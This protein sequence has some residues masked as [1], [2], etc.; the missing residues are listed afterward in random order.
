MLPTGMEMFLLA[1]EEMSF[2]RAAE[3]AFVSQQ[4]LSDHIRRLEETYHVVLFQ[5]KPRL[6][7]TP[8]GQTML[9]YLVRVRALMDDMTN[10]LADI[11]QGTRGTIRFGI[12]A[13]RGSIVIPKLIPAFQERFPN[14]DVTVHTKDTHGLEQMFLNGQL[15]VFLGVDAIQHALFRRTPLYRDSM[16]LVISDRL[17]RSRFPDSYGEKLEEFRRGADL[18]DLLDI[19]FVQGSSPSTSTYA[20]SQFLLKHSIQLKIPIMVSDFD[21]LAELCMSGNYATITPHFHLRR[22][23]DGANR[24]SP[25]I[26]VFP[27]KGWTQKLP[28]EI[29][30]LRDGRLPAHTAAFT[31]MLRDV[32]LSEHAAVDDCL[33]REG[34]PRPPGP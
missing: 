32:L 17:M 16:Y 31:E 4:C 26:H 6:Q 10:E 30:T 25:Q 12:G 1:A 29:I 23:M 18:N 28:V 5:R 2:T 13:T 27:I 14:V 33:E 8:E 21:V 34:L 11:S 3:R 22:L 19:P 7:L 24:L 9:K 15:D 20:V